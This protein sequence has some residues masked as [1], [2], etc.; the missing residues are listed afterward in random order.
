MKNRRAFAFRWLVVQLL[1]VYGFLVFPSREFFAQSPQDN[2]KLDALL[3]IT[4]DRYQRQWRNRTPEEL[5]RDPL[6]DR[7]ADLIAIEVE[8]RE[9][10]VP[11]IV[12]VRDGGREM[13][14]RG[15]PIQAQIGNIVTSKIPLRRLPALSQ[16]ASVERVESS[17]IQRI[18]SH[19]ISVPETK[20]VTARQSF[21]LTG[22][23][24]IVAILDTGIDWRHPDFRKPDGKTRIKFLW[25]QFDKTGPEP[26][27]VRG[28]GGTEYTEDQINAA[29][30]GAGTVN[31]FDRNGHGTHV[32]GSAAGNGRATGGGFPTGTFTGMAPEA[33][34]IIVKHGD[35]RG[36][37]KGDKDLVLL[38]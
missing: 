22:K 32:A 8:E 1:I 20:A 36:S 12:L 18:M 26:K 25:D 5:R 30:A 10:A 15:F 29:L 13:R 9:P 37:T 35:D 16:L 7:F 2:S 21:N 27:E 23:G 11:V 28:G 14:A 34:L 33:D 4:Y 17:S 31:S 3:R 24:A 6:L 19:D 38:C